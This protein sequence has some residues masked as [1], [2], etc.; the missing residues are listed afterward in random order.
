[1]Q[2][3][4]Q[5]HWLVNSVNTIIRKIDRTVSIID[6]VLSNLFTYELHSPSSVKRLAKFTE[7]FDM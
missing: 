3:I 2:D 1:L 5:K 4:L 7:K 6:T